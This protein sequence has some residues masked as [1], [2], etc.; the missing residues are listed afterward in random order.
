[1]KKNITI[2]LGL[3]IAAVFSVVVSYYAVGA[4]P[5]S[6]VAIAYCFVILFNIVAIGKKRF[7]RVGAVITGLVLAVTV[8]FQISNAYK[9][10]IFRKEAQKV[11]ADLLKL[12]STN[13]PMPKSKQDLPVGKLSFLNQI[14]DYTQE[15]RGFTLC[16]F[17]DSPSTAYCY[18][19]GRG[20]VYQDD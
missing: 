18:I 4:S 10:Y 20:W 17:V 12:E 19:S 1:M 11:V 16:Y 7:F 13:Q 2:I 8:P 5:A 14:V 9:L 3:L 15:G 6:F